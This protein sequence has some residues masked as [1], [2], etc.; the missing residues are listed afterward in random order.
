[1]TE[2][3]STVPAAPGASTPRPQAIS[4]SRMPP[5]S[6]DPFTP[7]KMPADPAPRSGPLSLAR[8]MSVLSRSLGSFRT[9]SNRTASW[10]SVALTTPR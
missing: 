5:S 9:A 3:V 1:M 7:R 2:V 4:G 10:S 8:M 6:S